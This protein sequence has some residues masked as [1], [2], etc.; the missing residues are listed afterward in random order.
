M[1]TFVVIGLNYFGFG[2]GFYDT[3]SIHFWLSQLTI[4]G[5]I[6]QAGYSDIAIDDV[7][8]DPGLCSE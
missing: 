1:Q 4:Q 8:I 2:F 7:Y 3:H 6:G 5:T